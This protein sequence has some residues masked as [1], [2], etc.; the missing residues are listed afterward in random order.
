MELPQPYHMLHKT[1]LINR[2]NLRLF[3]K[4]CK[5]YLHV[6]Y[7]YC[8]LRLWKGD[9]AHDSLEISR[10]ISLGSGLMRRKMSFGGKEASRLA[11][12]LTL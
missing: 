7:C 6:T 11:A 8:D 9:Q 3:E 4:N 1:A 10:T 12:F 5:S 2:D